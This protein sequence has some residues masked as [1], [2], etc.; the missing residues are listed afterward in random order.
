MSNTI[1]SI[2]LSDT[3]FVYVLLSLV[4]KAFLSKK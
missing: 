1:E 4:E 2:C 3:V